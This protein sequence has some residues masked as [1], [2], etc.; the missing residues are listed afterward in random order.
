MGVRVAIMTRAPVTVSL[1]R[2]GFSV[3][4]DRVYRGL[5]R[6]GRGRVAAVAADLGMPAA[7]VGEALAEL[8]YRGAVAPPET[9]LPGWRAEP[10]DRLLALL[11]DREGQHP[12]RRPAPSDAGAPRFTPRERALITLLTAGHSDA[13]AARG[14]GVSPRTVSSILR[15]LMDRLGVGNRFQLGVAV[16]RLTGGPPT[17]S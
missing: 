15:S 3:E 10:P 16:G 8:A 13:G 11:N 2:Y 4:A 9:G 12:A 6:R 1:V 7:Q 5:L 17:H 14:L